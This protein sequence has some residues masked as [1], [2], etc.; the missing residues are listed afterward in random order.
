MKIYFS[1]TTVVVKFLIFDCRKGGGKTV[2]ALYTNSKGR[3]EDSGD[4]LRRES[5]SD[6]GVYCVL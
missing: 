1:N 2:L 5:R 6:N 3:T 4:G